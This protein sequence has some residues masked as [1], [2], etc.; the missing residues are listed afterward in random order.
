MVCIR[1]A[2]ERESGQCVPLS[3]CPRM[4]VLQ[5]M[6]WWACRLAHAN[7][8]QQLIA[9]VSKATL[10]HLGDA[11]GQLLVVH[12]HALG[13]VQGHEGMLQE[14]LRWVCVSDGMCES[15]N[16][17]R[18]RS[19]HM[20]ARMHTCVCIHTQYTDTLH[21]TWARAHACTRQSMH[22]CKHAHTSLNTHAACPLAPPH[23]CPRPSL[24]APPSGAWQ[25]H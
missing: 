5:D 9:C 6:Q 13:L 25:S 14:Q 15:R 21:N 17:E 11:V 23:H 7:T 19:T 8:L 1:S 4:C 16:V 22:P 10:T 18:N 12:G 20:Q 3:H 2:R 24:C